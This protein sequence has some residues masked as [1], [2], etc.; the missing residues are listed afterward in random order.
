V[1]PSN[2]RIVGFTATPTVA[3]LAELAHKHDLLFYEDLGSG[4][5]VDLV[6]EPV[7]SESIAGALT[8]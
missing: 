5:L 1:H 6:G 8:S 3:E 4:A 7:V 2:Y